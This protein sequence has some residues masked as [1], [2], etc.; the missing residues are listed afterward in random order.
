MNKLQSKLRDAVREAGDAKDEAE[1]KSVSGTVAEELTHD[2]LVRR[3]LDTH[4]HTQGEEE[5][6]CGYRRRFCWS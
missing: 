1:V 5:R 3:A 4:T 6:V 2:I